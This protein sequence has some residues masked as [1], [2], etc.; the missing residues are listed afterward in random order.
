MGKGWPIASH[1]P[2]PDTRTSHPEFLRQL[3]HAAETRILPEFPYPDS[4]HAQTI[5]HKK[6]RVNIFFS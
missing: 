6:N 5:A 2:I 4:V 3:L 1:L